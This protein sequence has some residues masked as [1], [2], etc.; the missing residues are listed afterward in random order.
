MKIY[1]IFSTDI[2]TG[3]LKKFTMKEDELNLYDLLQYIFKN[4]KLVPWQVW[5]SGLSTGL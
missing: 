3:S 5:L 1:F 4:Y 2:N